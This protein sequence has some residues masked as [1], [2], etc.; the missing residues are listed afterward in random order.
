MMIDDPITWFDYEILEGIIGQVAISSTS[1]HNPSKF[2]GETN[3]QV[4]KGGS[5]PPLHKATH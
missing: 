1:Q 2:T 4:R 3:L 5:P